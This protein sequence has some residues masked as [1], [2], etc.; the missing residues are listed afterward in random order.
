MRLSVTLATAVA[1]LMTAPAVMGQS[2]LHSDTSYVDPRAQHTSAGWVAGAVYEL[3]LQNVSNTEQRCVV[4]WSFYDGRAG[5]WR[6]SSTRLF[7]FPGRS[8]TSTLRGARAGTAE[9][10]YHC[11]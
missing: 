1:L 8:E 3:T 2:I 10:S 7:I 11:S 6:T 5:Q 9:W 4:S